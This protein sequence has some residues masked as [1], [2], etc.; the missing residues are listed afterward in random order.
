[1]HVWACMYHGLKAEMDQTHYFV[2]GLKNQIS[3]GT[4]Q[5]TTMIRAIKLILAS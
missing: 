3:M 1:M 5:M 2:N 4:L